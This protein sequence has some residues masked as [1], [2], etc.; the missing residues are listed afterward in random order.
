MQHIEPFI[1]HGVTLHIQC[2]QYQY[3]HGGRT[4]SRALTLAE[5][6]LQ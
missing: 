6:G 3:I 5:E 1:L 2:L 4:A